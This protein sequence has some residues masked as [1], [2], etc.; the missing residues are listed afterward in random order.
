MVTADIR[1]ASMAIPPRL[2]E[3]YK[4][5]R[6]IH[7][8]YDPAFY[9][10]CLMLP[11][12]KRPHVDALYAHARMLDQ[13]VD[14]QSADPATAVERLDT[15]LADFARVL[16]DG[17]DGG[18]EADPV[19]AAAAHTAR[20]FDIPVEY[21][22]TFADAMRSDLTVTEYPTFEDLRVYMHGAAALLGL[23]LVPI[24]GPEHPEAS[25]RATS[26]GYALQMTNIL[27]DVEEDLDR[28]R[29]YLPLDDLERF[30][31][32]AAGLRERRM[33]E[34]LREL[35]RFEEARARDYYARAFESVEL[36]HPSSRQCVYTALTLY[37][38]ILDSLV[39][40]DYQVFGVRHGLNKARALRIALP[41]YIR[42]R[43]SWR[44][45]DLPS[46]AESDRAEQG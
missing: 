20:T 36:L 6:G 28:G 46:V 17:D 32:G 31:V 44:R 14:D 30:G 7:R 24:L 42:A 3:A 15:R 33:T 13:I 40:A 34:P 38:G 11:A 43:R 1:P 10:G 5:C 16:K 35:L 27:R 29:I 39:A 41:A 21:F 45:A 9:A 37:S 2:Q 26:V 18:S 8:G 19:L 23:Q 12:P 22:D 25:A 4:R